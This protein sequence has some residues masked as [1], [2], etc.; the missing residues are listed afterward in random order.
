M[1]RKLRISRQSS[2]N[3]D[4]TICT[5]LEGRLSMYF[6]TTCTRTLRVCKITALN[7]GERRINSWRC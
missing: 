4:P 5:R 2:S 7:S 3:F 6:C 1:P